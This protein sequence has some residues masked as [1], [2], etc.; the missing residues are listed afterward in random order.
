MKPGSTVTVHVSL[1]PLEVAAIIVTSPG[2]IA[3]TTPAV[4][5]AIA[6]FDELHSMDGSVAS[7]GDI[8]ALMVLN[9]PTVS[10]ISFGSRTK[11]STGMMSGITVI[12]QVAECPLVVEAVIVTS[13]GL[14]VV[15]KPDSLTVAI[16]GSLVDQITVGS[17][18]SAGEMIASSFTVRPSFSVSLS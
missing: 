12:M 1:I 2:E 15:T 5:V 3:V 4:T 13:P 10:V 7:A 16:S 18:A 9:S 11:V 6:G 8:T 14:I 17:V